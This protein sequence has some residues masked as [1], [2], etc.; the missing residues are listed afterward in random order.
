MTSRLAALLL[1][2]GCATSALAQ[3]SA[4]FPNRS[5]R[6]IVPFTAGSGAD[7]SSR[8]YGEQIGK[9]FGQQ[10]L[11]ENKP[12]GSGVVAVQAT[13]QAPADGHTILMGSNSPAVVNA[14]T[15]KNLPYDP[16]KDLR[17]LYGIAI[18]P[19]AFA[20]RA[21][22]PH[23]TVADLL[24]AAKKENR[25][26][27]LG[28]YSAGYQLVAAWLGTASALPVTHIPYKGGAQ[29]L[30][31]VVGGQLEVGVIDFTGTTELMKGG[32][33]RVL[34]I[35]ADK[36]DPKYPDIP[37]MRESGFPDFE[38]WVWSAFFVRAETPNDVVDK[39]AAA[40][41]KA[42]TSEAGRAYQATLPSAPLMMGPKELGEFQ[43]REYQRFKRVAELA[44]IKPE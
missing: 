6:I 7:S 28:N 23:K 15:M 8:F 27:Q 37:T 16:F 26:L 12:G 42:M 18:S 25:P 5:I 43:L 19:V 36:R 14:I 1:L 39:L 30:T 35:T 22:S 40:M 41:Q 32:R 38:T 11:V 33:L 29:M 21:D 17:P 9:G 31:D 20:V 24:A 13:R 3:A 34:A 44:G 4:P 2:L 10:V